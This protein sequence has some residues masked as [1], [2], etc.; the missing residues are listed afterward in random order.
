MVYLQKS[1]S[2]EDNSINS[3]IDSKAGDMCDYLY[4]YCIHIGMY[5]YICVCEDDY[6]G[7]HTKETTL[8]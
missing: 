7:P 4:I 6:G 2:S 5:I 8:T 1:I 3:L